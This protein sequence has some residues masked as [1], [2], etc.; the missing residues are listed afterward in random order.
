M[1]SRISTFVLLLLLLFS[2]A[3]PVLSSKLAN[4]SKVSVQWG[5]VMPPPGGLAPG[6]ENTTELWLCSQIYQMFYDDS[7]FGVQNAYG[8]LTTANN[9]QTVLQYCQWPYNYVDWA[10]T[11]WVGDFAPDLTEGSPPNH[12][13]F[14]GYGAANIFDYEVYAYANYVY[15]GWPYFW[16]NIPSKQYFNFIWT[17]VNAGLYFYS[18]GSTENVTGFTTF[19]S[20]SKPTYTPT[21]PFTDYGALLVDE[22]IDHIGGMPYGLT[23]TKDM[24]TNGYASPDYDS[25]CYIGFENISPWMV[26]EAYNDVEYKMFAY[27]FYRYALG[28]VDDTHH[29]IKQSLDYASNQVFGQALF[30]NTVLY[31]GEWKYMDF[32]DSNDKDGWWYCRMRVLGNGDLTLP[33]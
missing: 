19:V 3:T 6:G 24:S 32:P 28:V 13:G 33:S 18:D 29:T 8:N 12:R 30:S 21:N 25:Y 16:Q 10:T 23:G 22:F 31:S 11:W 2:A 9:L 20:G 14:Y 15:L 5:N 7:P 17:C 26:D 1:K 4:A 27:H